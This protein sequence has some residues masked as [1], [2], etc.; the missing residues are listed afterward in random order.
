MQNTSEQLCLPF[1]SNHELL[2]LAIEQMVSKHVVLTLTDN[3]SSMISFRAGR[4]KVDLRLHRMFLDASTDVVNE[5]GRF[6]RGECRRTPII[7]EFIRENR[8]V[9]TQRPPRRQSLRTCGQCHDLEKIA[10]EVNGKYFDGTLRV[11]ITWGR[12]MKGRIVRQRI[13][14]SFSRKSNVIRINPVLDRRRVPHYFLSFVVYHE[15]LHAHLGIAEVNGRRQIHTAEFRRRE[16]LFDSYE[17]AVAWEK[18]GL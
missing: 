18:T 7:R 1:S 10:R 15:M 13:L 11:F 17:R 6:I 4:K 2:R 3:V 12:A 8:P 9:I 14:G 5:L 16:R